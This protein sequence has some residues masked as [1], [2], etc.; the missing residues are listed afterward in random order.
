[1]PVREEEQSAVEPRV[2]PPV[3]P[4]L[5]VVGTTC[6]PLPATNQVLAIHHSFQHLPHLEGLQG[7]C[8]VV[9]LDRLGPEDLAGA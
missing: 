4:R 6:R 5:V 9:T 1:M 2:E 3:E 8:R 7:N